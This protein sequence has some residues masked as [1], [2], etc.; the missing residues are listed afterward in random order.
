MLPGTSRIKLSDSSKSRS[1][2]THVSVTVSDER[3]LDEY[4]QGDKAS[5]ESL[6]NRYQRELY[7]FL[8][9]FLGNRT[10]RGRLSGDISAG[11]SVGRGI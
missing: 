3:L 11:A 1:S 5:F 9:R 2:Y 8:V 10:A 6:V 4:R 7:H